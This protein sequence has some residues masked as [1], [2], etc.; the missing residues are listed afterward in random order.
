MR[1]ASW[2]HTRSRG[3]RQTRASAPNW[4]VERLLKEGVT[5]ET[6]LELP[7]RPG[8]SLQ[9]RWISLFSP[10]GERQPALV[11]VETPAEAAQL[12]R[13]HEFLRAMSDRVRTAARRATNAAVASELSMV[14]EEIDAELAPPTPDVAELEAVG[15]AER[16]G[17]W[18][19]SCRR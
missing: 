19:A 5:T 1:S 14:A 11:V 13:L 4:A 9:A 12:A 15:V 10:E 16:A 18:R 2:R 3:A 8:I 17:R 6:H 7:W